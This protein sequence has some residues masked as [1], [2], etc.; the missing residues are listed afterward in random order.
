MIDIKGNLLCA[1]K[2]ISIS[3]TWNLFTGCKQ[4]III[5]NRYISVR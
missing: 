5:F 2:T 3:N 4:M 1:N